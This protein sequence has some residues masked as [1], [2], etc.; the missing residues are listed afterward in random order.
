MLPPR[1][2]NRMTAPVISDKTIALGW[3]PTRDLVQYINT[4]KG[5]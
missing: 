4:L 2:G 3:K 5:E 1:K